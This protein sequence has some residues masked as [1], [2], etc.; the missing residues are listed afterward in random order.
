[1][2]TLPLPPLDLLREYLEIDETS[3]SG[4]RWKKLQGRCQ[5]KPGDVAGGHSDKGYWKINFTYKGVKKGYRAHRIVIYILTG[6]DPGN[7]IVDHKSDRSQNTLVRTATPSQNSANSV[8]CNKITS[9]KY[10]GVY[11]NTGCKKWLARIGVNRKRIHLGVFENE[12]DAARA[13]NDAA[14]KYFG[15]FAKLNIIEDM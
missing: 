15:E 9:S 10:K 7:N 11:W 13:Y 6:Q 8:K 12:C 2:K 5:K 14:L 3:P 4:L 1:M